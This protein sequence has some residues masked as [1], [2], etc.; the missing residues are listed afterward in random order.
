MK[1]KPGTQPV[2]IPTYRLPYKQRE[3]ENQ[4]VEE[5]LEEG[6]IQHS[7]ST[8]NSP[9]FLLPKKDGTFRPVFYF[10]RLN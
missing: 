2:Y 5:M 3:V 7:R 9:L 10:R 1:L 8:W 6:V 4:A